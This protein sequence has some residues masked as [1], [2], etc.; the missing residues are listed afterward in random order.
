MVKIAKYP[1]EQRATLSYLLRLWREGDDDR[2]EWRVSLRSTHSGEPLGLASL[3]ICTDS[4]SAR[5]A[6]HRRRSQ[7]DRRRSRRATCQ[8]NQADGGVGYKPATGLAQEG[9]VIIR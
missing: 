7:T 5:L 4:C 3:K 1:T 9:G 6:R 2:P 8:T